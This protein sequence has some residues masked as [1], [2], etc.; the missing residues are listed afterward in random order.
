MCG[1]EPSL[2]NLKRLAA[3]CRKHGAPHYYR[4]WTALTLLEYLN[5][6]VRQGTIAIVEGRGSRVEGIGFAFQWNEAAL[7][8]TVAENKPG[9]SLAA[10]GIRRAIAFWW[11]TSSCTG[12]GALAKLVIALQMLF[13]DWRDLKLFTMRRLRAGGHGLRQYPAR[14]S[15]KILATDGHRSTQMKMAA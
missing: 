13:P 12:R 1:L 6:N 10:D 14:I 8:K 3:F 11:V 4:E 5:F 2:E 9:V 7:R 15:E